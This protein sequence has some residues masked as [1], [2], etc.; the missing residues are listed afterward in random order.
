MWVVAG[1]GG[2]GGASPK[3]IVPSLEPAK[4]FEEGF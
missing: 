4:G 1:G 2:D 3:T